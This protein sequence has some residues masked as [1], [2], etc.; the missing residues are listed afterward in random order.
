MT[1]RATVLIP[2]KSRSTRI[3]HKNLAEL[4]GIPLVDW[5]LA[6]SRCWPVP[7]RVIMAADCPKIAAR[8]AA[9]HAEVIGLT[10]ADLEDRRTSGGLWRDV[11][12]TLDGPVILMQVTSPFR[13]LADL[14]A[15]WKLFNA[16]GHDMVLSVEP[17]RFF[18]L[19][20]A[21]RPDEP[22][23]QTQRLSQ[24]RPLRYHPV[25]S[26]FIADAS[27]LRQCKESLYDGR[28]GVV[29]VH[30]LGTL[31]VDTPD[32]LADARMIAGSLMAISRKTDE[33]A[34]VNPLSPLSEEGVR[35]PTAALGDGRG[36]AFQFD[37]RSMESG[38][39]LRQRGSDVRGVKMGERTLYL[40]QRRG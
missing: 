24:S 15:A 39:S 34:W 38:E 4:A 36:P 32:Q 20:A 28:V 27:Y 9:Y 16:G 13:C 31:D 22:S 33:Y 25:G 3:P 37:E 19:S 17:I 18:L 21:G 6:A 10:S 14:A 1:S 2:A 7:T 8:A 40:H 29:P 30:W 23:D 5:T 11:A 12:R 35:C 26:F